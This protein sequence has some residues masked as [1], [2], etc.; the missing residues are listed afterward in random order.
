M[1]ARSTLSNIATGDQTIF[2]KKDT[3][4][5]CIDGVKSHPIMEDIY[6]S[7][8]FKKH[9]G[10]PCIIHD[11]VATSTRYWEKH[12]VTKSIIKMWQFRLLYF[13]GMTPDE[14]YRLYY[15]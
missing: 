15:S 7:K 13:L 12:G 4:M 2:V 5:R 6:M 10:R 8:Y 1:I 9:Y 14:L 11:P 3:F